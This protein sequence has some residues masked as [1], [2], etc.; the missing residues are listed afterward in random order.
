ML[1][2][3][4][5][6][7]YPDREHFWTVN[8]NQSG[9]ALCKKQDNTT[10]LKKRV[11]RESKSALDRIVQ[12]GAQRMLQA[13]IEA[14][15]A[16]YIEVHKELRDENGHRLVVRNGHQPKRQVQKRQV[17]TGAGQLDVK[18]LRVHDR[19]EGQRFTSKILPPYMRRSPSLDALIPALY[20][21]GVSTGDFQ[22]ALEA[23]L[24]EG[25]AGLSVANIVRLKE[26]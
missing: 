2:M 4:I 22:E 3:G 23:I 12:E 1:W 10:R 9:H 11:A 17:Q 20:L 25:A 14:E 16:A 18:K 13:A 7:A 15:V 26:S 8:P 19:R 6:K 24:G 5:E 21:R